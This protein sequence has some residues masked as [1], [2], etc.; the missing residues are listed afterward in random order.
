MLFFESCELEKREK[1][2][3]GFWSPNIKL[4]LNIENTQLNENVESDDEIGE[5]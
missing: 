5:E 1:K 2:K 3:F 4:H